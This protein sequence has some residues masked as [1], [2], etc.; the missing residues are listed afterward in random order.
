MRLNVYV[1]VQEVQ[2]K[3]REMEERVQSESARVDSVR[4][5]N[6]D[7]IRSTKAEIK[8]LTDKIER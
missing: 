2:S 1:C 3:L 8:S 4:R 7:Q 6:S 5:E